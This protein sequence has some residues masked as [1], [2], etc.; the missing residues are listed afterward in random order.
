MSY[1]SISGIPD[2]RFDGVISVLGGSSSS[3]MYPTYLPKVNQRNA[4][5]CDY[6]IDIFGENS[7]GLTYDIVLDLEQVNGSPLSNLVAHLVITESGFPV[8]WGIVSEAN[9]VCREMVPD[10]NGTAISFSGSTEL[11]LSLQFT[12]DP[13]W[14][15]DE[16]ELV[17]FIQDNS[18]K[19]VLQG[20][21]IAL[22]DLQPFQATAYFSSSD[23][24]TCETYTVQYFDNSMGDITSR[25]WNF[26]GGDPATSSDENPVVTYNTHG[27]YDAELIVSD[28]TVTDTALYTDY[29]LVKSVPAQANTPAGPAGTCEGGAFEYTTDPVTYASSYNWVVEPDDAGYMSGSGTTGTFHAASGWTGAYIVKVRAENECG[30]GVYSNEF[31]AELNHTPV[32]YQISQGG[33]Y[34][35]GDP[36]IEVKVFNSEMDTDY[37]LY[38]E[39]EPTGTILPGTGD[40]LNFGHQTAEGIY[41]VIAFTDVCSNSMTGNAWIHMLESPEQPATPTGPENACNNEPASYATEGA[42]H[43]DTY[44]WY[45]DPPEAGVITPN[46]EE[47]TVEWEDGYTGASLITVEGENECGTGPVSDAFQTYVMDVPSP[48]ISGLTLVCDGETAD[49]STEENTGSSYVWDV[50]GGIIISGAGTHQVTV[51]WGEPGTGILAV[52]ETDSDGCSETTGDFEVNIDDCTGIEEF[53]SGKIRVYPNPARDILQVEIRMEQ[54]QRFSLRILNQ[55]GKVVYQ[56][57]ENIP[58]GDKVIRIDTGGLP[59]GLYTLSMRGEDGAS[60][61]KIFV[62]IR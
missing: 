33:G 12:L 58:S 25:T 36:G 28:G 59:E 19:E 60:V 18:S 21:K 30:D 55:L 9:Y 6:T 35:E 57:E 5:P 14:D 46:G 47:A 42:G 39:G 62:K 56:V 37:E 11:E 52:T 16:I 54:E 45:L 32:A 15:T 7:S 61:Q 26:E 8:S 43:A 17:A 34:C 4:I 29:V 27:E 50:S 1:Y 3:S 10:Q 41:T 44:A 20:D 48:D 2:V 13:S 23:T 31:T 53:L 40:T 22:N 49:Y 24:V 38:L 51:E